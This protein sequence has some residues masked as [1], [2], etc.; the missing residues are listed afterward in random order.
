VEIDC[1]KNPTLSQLQVPGQ[2]PFTYLLAK[3][4]ALMNVISHSFSCCMFS[5]AQGRR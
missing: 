1:E 2:K 3:F 5:L 4:L